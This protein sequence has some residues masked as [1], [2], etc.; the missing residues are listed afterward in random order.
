MN[1]SGDRPRYIL[2]PMP[3]AEVLL[4]SG[5]GG[6]AG[7][8]RVPGVHRVAGGGVGEGG[9]GVGDLQQGPV[10]VLQHLLHHKH[11]QRLNKAKIKII[12]KSLTF[13]Y[14]FKFLFI[15]VFPG[16][17][18]KKSNFSILSSYFCDY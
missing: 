14:F 2:L 16:E 15:I 5:E 10:L 1:R 6:D 18:I 17:A 11:T 3:E 12:I 7:V 8:P 4:L 9:G 13:W